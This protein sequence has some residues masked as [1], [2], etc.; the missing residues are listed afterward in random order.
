MNVFISHIKEEAPI[1]LELKKFIEEKFLEEVSV[2]ASSDVHDLTPGERWLAKIDQALRRSQVLL[3]VCSPSSLSRPWINFEAGCGWIKKIEIIPICHSGQRRDQLPFPFSMLQSLQIEDENFG[4]LLLE[5]IAKH[6]DWKKAPKTRKKC[7][8]A[9]YEALKQITTAEASPPIIRSPEERT[10][11]IIND[12]KT[13]LKSEGVENEIVWTSAFLSTFAISENDP[14][15]EERHDLLKLLLE[16]KALL[17]KLAQRGCTIKC[18]ISPANENYIRHAGIDYAIQRT[19]ELLKFL[20]SGNPALDY[21]EWAVSELGTKNLY[22]IGNISCFEGYKKGINQGY[23]LT[24]RQTAHDVVQANID[25]YRGFFEDL[26]ARTLAR[27]TNE[28]DNAS[29]K[30]E[31]L[32]IAAARSLEDSLKFLDEFK[33]NMGV[34]HRKEE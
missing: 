13:L 16:E 14:F 2:F 22:I 9:L 30:K 15:P 12:L 34:R 8:H 27:W 11:L 7:P 19:K 25:V 4:N 6:F 33:T 17:I 5:A 20:S 10:Q 31:L 21:I 29:N 23:G 32:R 18:I 3:V 28:N 24:L 1:A 26:E